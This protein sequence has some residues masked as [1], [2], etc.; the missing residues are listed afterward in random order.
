MKPDGSRNR[1]AAITVALALEPDVLARLDEEAMQM[2]PP[3]DRCDAIRELLCRAL[4]AASEGRAAAW[5]EA[6]LRERLV[7]TLEEL[8]A[9][10]R[11][12]DVIPLPALRAE[13]AR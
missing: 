3:R 10:C 12:G 6:R 9:A 4:D 1:S 13:M 11:Y 7:V 8:N 2:Q 5:D